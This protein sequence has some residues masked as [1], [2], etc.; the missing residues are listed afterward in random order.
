[1][2]SSRP[3]QTAAAGL[4]SALSAITN[5][6][7]RLNQKNTISRT[8]EQLTSLLEDESLSVSD[9]EI[10]S[11][12]AAVAKTISPVL[13]GL[14]SRPR[15][16]DNDDDDDTSQTPETYRHIVQRGTEFSKAAIRCLDLL[17]QRSISAVA[18]ADQ[19]LLT[20]T[21]FADESEPWI[22]SVE[23]ST[24]AS[25]LLDRLLGDAPA[26][27][28][29]M[30][31]S[32]L[33]RYLRPLFSKSKPE[34]ITSSGRKAAFVD[35]FRGRGE[36]LPD[37]SAET[38]PWKFT[39]LRAIPAVAWVIREADELFITKHWPLFI[40][41]LLT[42]VDD[43]ST[44]VRR[45]GLL[46]L[47]CFLEKYP[48]KTLHGTGLAQVFE[49]AIFPTLNFLPSLTPE[50]ESV[51]LLGPAFEALLCLARKQ[52]SPTTGP[53][54]KEPRPNS[55][56]LDKVLRE[57]V[58]SAYFHCKDHP[59]IVTVLCQ[60]TI[61]IANQLGI[62][63]VKHLKDLIPMLSTILSNPFGPA[64]PATLLAAIKALQAVLQTCWPRIPTSPWQ[65]EIINALSLCW[66][67][68]CDQA[69]RPGTILSELSATGA[70][71]AAVLRT[72]GV[73]LADVVAPLVQKEPLLAALF[74]SSP[75]S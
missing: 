10:E 42:L 49:D 22:P 21:A 55:T 15:T 26:K 53:T 25:N 67:A 17:A 34:A 27:E 39:D 2:A 16:N 46:V 35:P 60:Q 12:A 62:H 70:M 47:K 14:D 71:L 1:M 20:L 64:A 48:S 38:K 65:D 40:P 28:Q 36:G 57:G 37:D 29:F 44:G 31:E 7:D 24:Q 75:S 19:V 68:A 6:G 72:Q 41:V 9:A 61:S 59:R 11:A 58:F 51:Q 66:L 4:N 13:V 50:D 43:Q 5:E 32:V 33:Q 54:T 23:V 63:T 18:A 30:A 74:A 3:L 73:E 52:A 56:L 8:I 69:T 45:Q